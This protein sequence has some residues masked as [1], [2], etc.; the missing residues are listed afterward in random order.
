[1]KNTSNDLVE[2]FGQISGVMEELASSSVTITNNQ[3]TLNKEIVNVKAVSVQI[4]EILDSIKG[5]ADQTKM[6]GLNAAIEAA[7]AGDA[8]RGFGVVAT[9]IRK[10]SENS[11]ETAMQIVKLTANIQ[12]SVQKTLKLSEST[13]INTEQ[14]SAAIQQTTAS[15]EEVLSLAN[16][17][18]AMANEK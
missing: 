9:E 15:I 12:E 6:L 13:M 11:K 18:N 4:N 3:E 2:S 1:M 7:R 16:E 17:L 5:I 14:Q 10:L 8:G